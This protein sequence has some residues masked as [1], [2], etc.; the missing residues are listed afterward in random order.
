MT[1]LLYLGRAMKILLTIHHP[2]D[3]HS[4]APGTVLKLGQLYQQLGHE[5]H[6]LSH[7]DLPKWMSGSLFP[8]FVATYLHRQNQ[9]HRFDVIDASTGDAWVWG[10]MLRR[11]APNRPLLVTRSHGLEHTVHLENLEEAQRGNLHLSWKYPLYR[12]S[13][14]LWEVATSLRCADQVFLLNRFDQK[15]A[16]EVLGVRSERIAIT[17]NGIPDQFL[18]LPLEPLPVATDAPLQIACIGTYI[19]RKGIHYSV[20]ALNWVLARYP[21]VSVSFL[22]TGCSA[23][24]VHADF[25]ADVRDRVQVIPKFQHSL[26]PNLLKGHAIKLF[27][28]LSEGFGKALIEAMA[29]GLAPVTT[30]A[31]G[32]LE[33]V[34]DGH[35][36]IVVP[37][38]NRQVIE[39]ALDR[40]INDRSYLEQL[41][42][43]AH[44]TAQR[45]R[46]L[47]AAQQRLDLYTAAIKTRHSH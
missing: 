26:L 14:L 15:Y 18:D 43:N 45:Y 4:G 13:V 20:P 6:Y 3:P 12:G 16:V 9:R 5:V 23:A 11:F 40:L 7:D 39:Q 24:E 21:H 46:W 42:Y 36:A 29:C 27:A 8:E 44:A 38:R 1:Q 31:A 10:T 37:L 30:A 47:K 2:L 41:R 35:D 17:P 19:S 32:P 33:V 25:D 22:G 28:P 34:R